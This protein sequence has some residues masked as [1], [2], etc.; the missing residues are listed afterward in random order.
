MAKFGYIGNQPDASSVIVAKQFRTLTAQVG[1][2][3]FNAGYVPGYI[4][5]FLNGSKLI[6]A[7]DYTATDGNIV[8]IV[9]ST[10]IGDTVE[11]VAYKAF[12]LVTASSI[13][14]SSNREEIK[15]DSVTDLNFVGS[16]F[17]FAVSGNTV[18]IYKNFV[19]SAGIASAVVVAP[20]LAATGGSLNLSGIITA[21]GGYKIGIQS[22]GED[23]ATGVIT[24][25]NFVGTGNTLVYNAGTKTVDISIQSGSGG[26]S[27]TGIA[28]GAIFSNPSF[29]GTSFE[30]TDGTN[31]YGV[32]GPISIGVGATIT[33]GAGNTFVVV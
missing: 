4:D 8:N 20:G 31:N 3:T 6:D 12:N 13:G 30:L 33:V 2:I 9:T 28:T 19:D 1:I 22:A 14:V 17:S 24:A 16:G 11:M 7:V 29:I 15:G 23:I 32:F 10:G 21:S 26:I 27:S 5:V 18:D 25:L